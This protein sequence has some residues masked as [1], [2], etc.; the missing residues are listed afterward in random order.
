MA[1]FRIKGTTTHSGLHIPISQEMLSNLSHSERNN[2]YKQ[3]GNV[4]VVF[5]LMKYQQLDVIYLTKLINICMKYLV[6]RKYLVVIMLLQLVI[7]IK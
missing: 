4:K 3:Y 1:A 5:L 2:L 6:V 7:F